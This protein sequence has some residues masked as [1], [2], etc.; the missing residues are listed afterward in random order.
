MGN[1]ALDKVGQ[2]LNFFSC[3]WL[4]FIAKATWQSP[5]TKRKFVWSGQ[6]NS[7]KPINFW[8]GIG[9]CWQQKDSQNGV[10]KS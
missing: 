7:D 9:P 6:P 2:K 8:F 10:M 5:I 3:G 1:A 4:V